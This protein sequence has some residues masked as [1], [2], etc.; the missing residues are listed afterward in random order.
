[1][2]RLLQETGPTFLDPVNPLSQQSGTPGLSSLVS[3]TRVTSP[4]HIPP[5]VGLTPLSLS[6][7]SSEDL[8]Y[9]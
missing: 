4:D 5:L 3:V 2:S 9:T 8:G 1:M 6:G 7:L